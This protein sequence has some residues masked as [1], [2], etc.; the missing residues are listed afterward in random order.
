MDQKKGQRSM[1]T[2]P[3]YITRGGERAIVYSWD[4]GGER[5][6]HGAYWTGDGWQPTA[7]LSTGRWN[8]NRFTGLDLLLPRNEEPLCA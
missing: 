7:W 1:V 2:S 3:E 8:E 4:A 5:P 6:I